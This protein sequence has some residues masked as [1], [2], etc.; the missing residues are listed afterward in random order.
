[1]EKTKQQPANWFD[2]PEMTMEEYR[3][4]G[5][6]LRNAGLG[7]PIIVTGKPTDGE[8]AVSILQKK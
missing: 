1:M 4:S 3:K 6:E 7:N 8:M 5:V 2:T